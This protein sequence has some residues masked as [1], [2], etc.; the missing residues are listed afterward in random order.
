MFIFPSESLFSNNTTWERRSH[1][2]YEEWMAKDFQ[3]PVRKKLHTVAFFAVSWSLWTTRNKRIFEAQELDL[4]TLSHTIRWRIAWWS[5]A[6][7]EPVHYTTAELAR[8]FNLIS[9][10][11]PQ[12]MFWLCFDYAFAVVLMFVWYSFTLCFGLLCFWDMLLF[13]S[14]PT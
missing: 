13:G 6:W 11:F 5:K 4:S 10:L 9:R 1:V 7:K 3:N 12:F 2:F 8:N 14:P